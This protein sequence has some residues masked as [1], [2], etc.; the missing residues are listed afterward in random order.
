[1]GRNTIKA[2]KGERQATI[3]LNNFFYPERFISIAMD[4]FNDVCIFRREGNQLILKPKKR[5]ADI[6]KVGYEFC[7]YA[8]GLIKNSGFF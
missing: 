8:L 6:Q 7:N 2:N 4:D 3:T 5:G 1:M